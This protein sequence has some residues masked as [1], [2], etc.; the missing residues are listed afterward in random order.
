[1]DGWEGKGFA[2][3]R[4]FQFYERIF[5]WILF[6]LFCAHSAEFVMR[7]VLGWDELIDCEHL[8][9]YLYEEECGCLLPK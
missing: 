5:Y 8:F 6:L 2:F 4:Y 7:A 9:K 3:V 1:M